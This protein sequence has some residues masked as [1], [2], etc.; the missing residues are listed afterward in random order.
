MVGAGLPV[1]FLVFKMISEVGE[2]TEVFKYVTLYS[3]FNPQKIIAGEDFMISF[4]VL[5]VIALVTYIGGIIVFQ[6][7]DLPL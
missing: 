5:G 6:N 7:R 2:S 4:V 1:G 3:L